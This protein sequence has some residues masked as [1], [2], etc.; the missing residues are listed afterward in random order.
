MLAVLALGLFC[1]GDWSRWWMTG[2]G[3]GLLAVGG[4]FGVAG[5]RVLGENR[6]PFPRPKDGSVLI[7]HGIYARV[8]HP[9]YTSVM[10]VSLG[11]ALGWQSWPAVAVAVAQVPFFLAKARREEHWLCQKFPGYAEY[12]RQVPR[13]VP[14]VRRSAGPAEMTNNQ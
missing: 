2:L 12:A 9:L 11:W 13:F 14:G 3:V 1:P 10:L 7:Q 5:V 8:R 6:T 4:F